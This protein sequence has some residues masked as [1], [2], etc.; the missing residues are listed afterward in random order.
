V[1]RDSSV[2][3]TAYLATALVLIILGW[4][5]LLGGIGLILL[6]AGL[7]LLIGT[8]FRRRWWIVAALVAGALALSAGYLL[9]APLGCSETV[10]T[11]P[12]RI[13]R[14]AISCTRVLLPDLHRDTDSG[15]F[16]LAVSIGAA[17]AALVG[18]GT[19]II[20]SRI[21]ERRA[22]PSQMSGPR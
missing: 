3:L 11:E 21:A 10:E 7:A 18:V 22:K 15:D 5:T 14:T 19:G 1:E 2:G 20:G 4:L 6:P 17:A 12:G 9:T 8:P 16:L 13:A